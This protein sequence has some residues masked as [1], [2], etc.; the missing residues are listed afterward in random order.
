MQAVDMRIGSEFFK[1]LLIMNNQG[2]KGNTFFVHLLCEEMYRNTKNRK[3][4]DCPFSFRIA[5]NRWNCNRNSKCRTNRVSNCS[6]SFPRR[7][8]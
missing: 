6:S 1:S 5:F 8:V 7:I 3:S 2:T 4:M